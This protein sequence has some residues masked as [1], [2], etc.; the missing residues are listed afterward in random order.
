MNLRPQKLFLEALRFTLEMFMSMKKATNISKEGVA[1]WVFLELKSKSGKN[2]IIGCIYRHHCKIAKKLIRNVCANEKNKVCVLMGD[3]NLDL[4][5]TESDK[6]ISDFYDFLCSFGFRPLI[7][8]PTQVTTSTASLIDKIFI[9]SL[10]T[11]S[12]GD[13]LTTSISDHFYQF[14]VLDIFNKGKYIPLPRKQRD[15]KNF[16]YVEFGEEFSLFDWPTLLSGKNSEEALKFFYD[17]IEGLL[18]ELAP[19]KT[20]NQK[21]KI[22]NK[23]LG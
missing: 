15:F 6:D 19:Y 16:S 7:L 5:K 3:F 10:E 9:N 12:K 13:N 23:G 4:L 18:D 22:F 20:L 21:S 2:V 11:E 8:Q 17:K 14:C 1:E